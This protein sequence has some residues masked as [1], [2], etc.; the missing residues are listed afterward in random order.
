VRELR[1]CGQGQSGTRR[2]P[3]TVRAVRRGVVDT[4]TVTA[5]RDISGKTPH[6]LLYEEKAVV[7]FLRIQGCAVEMLAITSK[8]D[9]KERLKAVHIQG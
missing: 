1:G 9:K 5:S 2:N 8:R 6:E 7:S 4:L 3:A